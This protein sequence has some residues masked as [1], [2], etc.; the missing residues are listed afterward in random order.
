MFNPLPRHVDCAFFWVISFHSSVFLRPACYL[1]TRT[2][3]LLTS[4]QCLGTN[5]LFYVFLFHVITTLRVKPKFILWTQTASSWKGV[6]L[7]GYKVPGTYLGAHWSGFMKS[8]MAMDC[9]TPSMMRW[10]DSMAKLLSALSPWRKRLQVGRN[11]LWDCVDK[12]V[13]DGWELIRLKIEHIYWRILA[14][15]Y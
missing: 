11:I 14:A 9:F 10:V 5:Q 7:H 12:P 2:P 13:L 4:V 15:V 8:A 6:L 3:T 1:K